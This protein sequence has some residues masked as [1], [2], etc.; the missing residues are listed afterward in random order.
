VLCCE[1][2]AVYNTLVD[3]ADL[4]KL[5]FSL[6]DGESP[7]S[8]KT[9]GYFGR[10][11]GNLLMRKGPEMLTYLQVGR[12]VGDRSS[13]SWWPR[14]RAAEAR[15]PEPSHDTD[16]CRP[17]SAACRPTPH[18]CLPHQGEGNPLLE[19]L[20]KHVGTTSIA[21]VVKRVLG[22]DDQT[23]MVPPPQMAAWLADTPLMGLLLERLSPGFPSEVQ[24]RHMHARTHTF[25]HITNVHTHTHTTPHT[26]THIPT[27]P[28]PHTH[29]RGRSYMPT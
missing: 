13:G 21:D 18:P 20:V 28:T 22:A 5:L 3:D 29:T 11:V 25:T 16:P 23:G 15:L 10:V 8:C 26:A 1:L 14:V 2:E 12:L 27:T 24:V 4:M 6:L 17:P 9:A 19:K 7:L